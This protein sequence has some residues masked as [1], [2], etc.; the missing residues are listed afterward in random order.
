MWHK[1][2]WRRSTLAPL[3]R[4]PTN[5]RTIIPKK[6]SHCCKNS[7]AHNRF[8]NLGIWQRYQEP[9][10]NLTLKPSGI[11]LQNFHRTGKTETLEGK[12]KALCAPGPRRKKQW[13]LKRLSKTYLW[14]SRSLHQRH[15][16]TVAYHRVR[17]L[18]TTVLGAEAYW[19]K[20]FWRR[21]PLP[22]LC[23]YLA[24]GQTTG[25][26]HNPPINKNCIKVLLSMAQSIRTRSSFPL[27]QSLPTESF[28]K[29]FTL[30]QMLW[31]PQS[32]KTNQS[33]HMDHSLV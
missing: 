19:H 29:P 9:Q 22:P 26:E 6:F 25:R 1:P 2:S 12:N 27:S 23:L 33:D 4:L 8:P 21:L 15:G 10:G 24:S 16:L 32:Q 31:K 5:W 20:S 13:S 11:W 18:T 30:H 28:H 17:A 3:S 14:V 7:R